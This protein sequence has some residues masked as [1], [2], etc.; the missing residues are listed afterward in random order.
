MVRELFRGVKLECR[1]GLEDQLAALKIKY[2]KAIIT[3][4]GI[5]EGIDGKQYWNDT[6]IIAE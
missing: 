6:F 3:E 2:P 4:P 5:I 1:P